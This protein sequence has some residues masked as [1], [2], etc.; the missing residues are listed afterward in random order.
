MTYSTLVSSAELALHLEDPHWVILDCR[1]DLASPDSGQKAH[2]AA[3]LPG[4]H[5]MHTDR[6]LAG[7]PN[8]HNGRHPLPDTAA[9]MRT[10]SAAGIS[11]ASQVIAYDAQGGLFASRL[12]W[13]LRHWLGHQKVAVLD[14][15]WNKWLA[16][17]RPQNTAVP[18]HATGTY[19]AVARERVVDADYVLAHLGEPDMFLLDARAADRYRGENETLDPVGGH[20]PGAHQRFFRDNLDTNGQFKNGA[21]LRGEFERLL[22]GT[23]ASQVV[24]QCGSGVS[25]C[26][27]ALAMDIAGLGG[28][29][30]YA[31]SWSE[32]CA[33]PSRPVKT[34]PHP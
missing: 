10:L 2:A 34:G 5:F 25:A 22:D 28:H 32:W 3:H 4:A 31:G 17:G 18:G 23:P 8:G 7:A 13:M 11:A 20:I 15:G 33:A 19:T 12:W 24:H 6:D 16:E 1:H 14:G 30:V 26:H 21:A 27:N 29:K 9:F